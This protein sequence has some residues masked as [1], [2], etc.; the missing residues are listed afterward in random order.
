[1]IIRKAETARGIDLCS[2]S[3]MTNGQLSRLVT[4]TN[5][6]DLIPCPPLATHV[7]DVSKYLLLY[8]SFFKAAITR[9]RA[10]CA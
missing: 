4:V 7:S 6:N 10:A 9:R 3:N 5:G 1:M 8:T 2:I